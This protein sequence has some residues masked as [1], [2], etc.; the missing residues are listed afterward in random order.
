MRKKTEIEVRRDPP[1]VGEPQGE[2]DEICGR[3]DF[4]LER[5]SDSEFALMLYGEKGDTMCVWLTPKRQ[6]SRGVARHVRATVGWHDTPAE[7]QRFQ[8]DFKLCQR[9]PLQY[10]AMMKRRA[11]KEKAG[12]RARL[13]D[14]RGVSNARK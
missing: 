11:A 8:R 13:T 4:H 9:D 2:I 6:P 12:V 5:M 7:R 1:S 14:K 10:V 3:G